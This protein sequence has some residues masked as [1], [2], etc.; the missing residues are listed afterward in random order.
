MRN[1]KDEILKANNNMA[2]TIVIDLDGVIVDFKNCKEKCD[3]SGYPQNITLK[4]DKCPLDPEAKSV[5][6]EIAKKGYKIVI[7]TSRVREE[8]EVTE[9]WLEKHGIT[10][11]RLEMEKP[12]ARIYIDDLAHK[13][14]DWKEIREMMKN[15]EI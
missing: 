13:F 15:G 1:F 12:R 4:R 2:K 5:L 7:Y 8:R 10:Y 6:F 11:H 3:Y 9:Q 14:T